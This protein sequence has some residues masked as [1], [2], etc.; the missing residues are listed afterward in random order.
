MPGLG[1]LLSGLGQASSAVADR[2]QQVRQQQVDQQNRMAEQQREMQLQGFVPRSSLPENQLF[3]KFGYDPNTAQK[4]PGSMQQFVTSLA[5]VGPDPMIDYV[6]DADTHP[7]LVQERMAAQAQAAQYDLEWMTQENARKLA[8]IDADTEEEIARLEQITQRIKDGKEIALKIN[9]QL[10]KYAS[11]K[12]EDIKLLTD[13]IK[14]LK[15]ELAEVE[16]GSFFEGEAGRIKREATREAILDQLRIMTDIRDRAAANMHAQLQG[17]AFD[18]NFKSQ[19]VKDL[20]ELTK[21]PDFADM[22]AKDVELW[23]L[24]QEY[25]PL[26]QPNPDMLGKGEPYYSKEMAR[27][28]YYLDKYEEEKDK[29]HEA[30]PSGLKKLLDDFVPVD[31]GEM[32]EINPAI[33]AGLS[34]LPGVQGLPIPLP[35]AQDESSQPVLSIDPSLINTWEAVPTDSQKFLFETIL[36]KALNAIKANVGLKGLKGMTIPE[37]EEEL[38]NEKWSLPFPDWNSKQARSYMQEY[39]Q[40]H[41]GFHGA[42]QYSVSSARQKNDPPQE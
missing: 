31:S 37:L 10:Y 15:I 39:L 14:G 40:K 2:A 35:S 19:W 6:A 27:V 23:K 12:V 29:I 20:E 9:E 5:D 24:A 41:L 42:M 36:P 25:E 21:P 11:M 17:H 16:E 18:K 7:M 28:Q 13:S 4:R 30:F 32:G 33:D 8:Q 3:E 22:S 26:I 34:S 1:D 38:R